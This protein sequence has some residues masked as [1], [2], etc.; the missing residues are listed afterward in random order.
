[1]HC[2]R[3]LSLAAWTLLAACGGG[4]PDP[5]SRPGTSGAATPAGAGTTGSPS[6]SRGTVPMTVSAEVDGKAYRASGPGECATSSE[7]SIYDVPASQWHALWEGPEGS[8]IRR[9]NLIVW[10][11]KDGGPDMVGL[12]LQTAET[13]HQIATVKGGRLAGSGSPGVRAEGRGG[14]L[15]VSGEDDH[16]DAVELAVQCERFDEV[17]AEG[18]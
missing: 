4:A 5:G 17:V 9:I 6:S 10:R 3:S 15:T 8:A 1:M 13:T 14:I 7:S 11:P 18:G 2:S 12:S 16:G